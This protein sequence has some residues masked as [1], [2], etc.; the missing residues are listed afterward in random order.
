M[1]NLHFFFF[2]PSDRLFQFVCGVCASVCMP[3]FK[4]QSVSLHLVVRKTPTSSGYFKFNV[5]HSISAVNSRGL[6]SLLREF[7]GRVLMWYFL[8]DSSVCN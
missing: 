1:F 5:R 8:L 3:Y 2:L 6:D 4:I 7:S